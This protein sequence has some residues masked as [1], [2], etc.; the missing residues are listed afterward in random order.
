MNP[1]EAEKIH[2]EAADHLDNHEGIK[3]VPGMDDQDEPEQGGVEDQVEGCPLQEVSGEERI[4]IDPSAEN[5]DVPNPGNVMT[6]G[7]ED[8]KKDNLEDQTSKK[9]SKPKH[10]IGKKCLIIFK[11]FVNT[12]GL[13][14]LAEWGDRS[15]IATVVMAS[16]N[17]VGGIILGSIAGHTLCTLLAVVAGALVA[18]KISVRTVT[19]IGGFVFVGFAIATL[20]LGPD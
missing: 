7:S 6:S 18:K 10:G 1:D 13:I 8:L 17:H 2:K 9:D 12:F 16:V 14:F 4:E 3:N 20:I 15:Q 19:I 11:L 5:E